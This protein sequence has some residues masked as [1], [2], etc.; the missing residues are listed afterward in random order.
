MIILKQA[1]AIA[2][3]AAIAVLSFSC[4]FLENP[5]RAGQGTDTTARLDHPIARGGK[6]HAD[7]FCR[8]VDNCS[9]CHGEALQGGKNGEPSCTKCHGSLWTSPN[10]GNQTHTVNLGGV[11]HASNYCRPYQNCSACH[12]SDLRGDSNKTP[13]CLQCHT[14]RKWMNCGT[15]QHNQREEGVLHASDKKKPAQDCAPCHG[16][17][18]RG[19][20]NGEPSCYRCHGKKW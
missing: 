3:L 13:S 17:D 6:L 1:V 18:L 4:R 15:T 20:P 16:S 7:G 2:G 5:I 10:C 9:A 11:L 12:G 14:Q 19:G 8:P